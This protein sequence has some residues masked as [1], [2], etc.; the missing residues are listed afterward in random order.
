MPEAITT[1]DGELLRQMVAGDENAFVALY[2]RRQVGVYRFAVQMC[3]SEAIAE[4]VTQEVFMALIRDASRYDAARGSVSTYLYGIARNQV[5][6]HLERD[7]RWIKADP[8]GDERDS[9]K[10]LLV[11][12]L[13]PLGDMARTETIESVRHAILS[14]PP[15]YR[16]VVVLFELHE[17]SYK[18]VAVTLNCAVGTVRSRLHR[19]RSMLLERLREVKDADS[20]AR[21]VKSTRCFA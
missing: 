21:S 5:L 17:M 12:D 1:D 19:A 18:E 10:E 14:L 11:A 20:A 7:R 8:E 16:E 6:R 9:S 13:D 15:H 2:R 4:D 3:G